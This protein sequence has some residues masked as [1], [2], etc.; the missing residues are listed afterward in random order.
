MKKIPIES[1]KKLMKFKPSLRDTAGFFGCSEDTIA[2]RIKDAEGI[3]FFE[4]RGRHVA[5]TKLKLQHK[6]IQMAMKGDK[7]MLIFTLKNLSGWEDNP[8]IIQEQE[9][10]DVAFIDENGNE[11]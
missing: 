10:C 1:L 8:K 4:F 6:A 7:T 3:S 9:P 11:F 5:S 2:R